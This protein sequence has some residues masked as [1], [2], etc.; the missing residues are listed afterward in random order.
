MASNESFDFEGLCVWVRQERNRQ[1]VVELEGYLK[2]ALKNVTTRLQGLTEHQTQ[3]VY[4]GRLAVS[5][6]RSYAASTTT[7]LDV[8]AVERFQEALLSLPSL[9][10]YLSDNGH[11]EAVQALDIIIPRVGAFFPAI[12]VSPP[13]ASPPPDLD[14]GP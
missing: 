13:P 2:K 8:T 5:M 6:L 3:M 11:A 9:R 12:L 4:R 7:A 1:L 10:E 14:G